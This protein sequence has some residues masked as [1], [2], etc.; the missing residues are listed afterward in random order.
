MTAKSHVTCRLQLYSTMLL[1]AVRH[2]LGK[3]TQVPQF[4]LDDM[5][6]D[7]RGGEAFVV[8]TQPRRIA[9]VGVAERVTQ[10]RGEKIGGAVG[11]LII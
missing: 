11:V 2:P 9:A 10:E 6:G 1:T 5:L 3:S 7:G 4:V 8:C